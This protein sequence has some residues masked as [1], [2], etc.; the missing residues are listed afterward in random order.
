MTRI[1]L[2]LILFGTFCPIS[3]GKETIWSEDQPRIQLIGPRLSGQSQEIVVNTLNRYFR[4]AFG[5]T[6]PVADRLNS[7]A[8]NLVV[9][10]ETN[11]SVLKSLVAD[12]IDL[13]TAELGDEGFRILTHEINGTHVLIVAA[14]TPQG[15]KHGCQELMYF[16]TDATT[17]RVS[18]DW[19]LDLV[20]KPQIAYRGIYMLPIWSAHDSLDSWKR[21]LQ[22]NSELTLNR[23]WFWLDGFPVAGHPA[24]SHGTNYHFE[25]TVL[26]KDE[27]VQSL[28]DLVNSEGMRFSI[29]GGWLSW[30][31][32]EVVGQDKQ[33]AR[34]YYFDYLKAFKG[35]CGFYFEPTGE[36]TERADWLPG[37]S[38]QKMVADLLEMDPTFET[39]VAIGS[40]NNSDYLEL[41]AQLDP[42]RVFWWWCWGDPIRD[43]TLNRYPSV[44]GW[45]T[46]TQMSSFHGRETPPSPA[47][48]VL[49]GMATS[50]DPGMGY[51][52][53]WNGWA[54]MGVYEPRNF[55]PYTMP[56][57][58]HQ[59]KF[60]ER[61]WNV[62]QTDEE[63]AA[64]LA[65]RLFDADVPSEAIAHYLKLDEFCADP[66]AA[67]A[68]EFER[69]SAF[70]S[71][72]TGHGTPR[73]Q[74]TLRRMQE[75]VEGIRK[76]KADAVSE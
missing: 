48:L 44:L 13:G 30:H 5:W 52:N 23:I 69:I 33:K 12:G 65:R 66:L 10:N 34:E 53:P 51:G 75:A 39:V 73:K 35:V 61:C 26:A 31:H 20:M 19:P 36:G 40:F 9:G 24:S 54:K 76:T 64:R 16:R 8:I 1:C 62:E 25:N 3:M 14:N 28:I 56:Y 2:A 18:I 58:S 38:L 15:L 49:A 59:Y 4:N 43:Q 45:H 29:G 17:D 46:T 37:D 55:D 11:N 6:I 67:D 57:F 27:N 41:M 72:H 42:K 50:Y 71:K 22:F 74:D 32:W 7:T 47:D 60:R 68:G 63:F 70:V 21:V